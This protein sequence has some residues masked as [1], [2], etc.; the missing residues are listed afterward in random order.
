[1]V[2]LVISRGKSRRGIQNTKPMFFLSDSDTRNLALTHQAYTNSDNHLH[3]EPNLSIAI[4][5]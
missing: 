4:D 1:M 3:R 2:D 5:H